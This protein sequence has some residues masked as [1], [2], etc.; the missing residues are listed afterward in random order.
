MSSKIRPVVSYLKHVDKR[1]NRPELL[2]K[3]RYQLLGRL[4]ASGTVTCFVYAVGIDIMDIR[5][6]QL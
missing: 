4:M 2:N 3:G 6:R 1:T 5:Y